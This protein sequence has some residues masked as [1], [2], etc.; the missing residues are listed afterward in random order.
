ME[1]LFSRLER[2]FQRHL[3]SYQTPSQT[4]KKEKK[5]S[6]EIEKILSEGR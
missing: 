4:P 2:E 1:I 3:C 5:V 6:K